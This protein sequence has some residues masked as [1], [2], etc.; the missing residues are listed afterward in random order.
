MQV[1]ELFLIFFLNSTKRNIHVGIR[2]GILCIYNN[3]NNFKYS[4]TDLTTKNVEVSWSIFIVNIFCICQ[5]NCANNTHSQIVVSFH[6]FSFRK[7]NNSSLIRSYPCSIHNT[8][9]LLY[10]HFI[11]NVK[12][13]NKLSF[14]P[15]FQLY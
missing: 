1:N 3:R 14:T 12:Q 5:K 9:F 10:L 8:Y 11:L 13:T 15:K 6:L 4:N 2:T 7:I